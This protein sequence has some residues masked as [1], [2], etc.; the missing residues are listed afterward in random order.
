MGTLVFSEPQIRGW[1]QL[2]LTTVE[3]LNDAAREGLNGASSVSLADYQRLVKGRYADKLPGSDYDTK[4]LSSGFKPGPAAQQSS[5]ST[6][7]L[8]GGS[9]AALA[10]AGGTL[11]LR[12]KRAAKSG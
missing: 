1:Y 2:K 5:A 12:R 10:L 6:P 8:L 11:V 9:G 3:P 7:L 4:G